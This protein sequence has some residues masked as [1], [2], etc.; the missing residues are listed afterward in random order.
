MPYLCNIHSHTTYSDGRN[1]PEEMVAAALALR[2]SALGFS[3]H[4][5]APHDVCSMSEETEPLYRAEIRALQKKYAGSI[6]LA[7][8][9]EHDASMADTDLSFYDYAIES[10][11]FVHPNGVY[12][13]VDESA[14]AL[15][16]HIQTHY[17]GDPYALCADYFREVCASFERTAAQVA[18]HIGLVTKFN[19]GNAMFNADD[20]RYTRPAQEAV[21]LAVEKDMLVEV[22]TGAMSRGYRTEPYPGRA[23]LALLRELGGRVIITSDCHRAE[24]MNYAFDSTL[25]LLATLGFRE[26]WT[27]KRGRFEPMGIQEVYA[28]P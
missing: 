10:V 25:D 21:R 24:W 18:G 3:D 27:W 8:G 16:S 13:S 4:G 7:L 14:A 9:Y 19:E 22:N 6:E 2:F 5:Y 1:T 17:G 28:N 12:C 15:A 26:V 23:L 20:P 11:H